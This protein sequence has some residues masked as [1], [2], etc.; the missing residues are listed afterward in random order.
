MEQWTVGPPGQFFFYQTRECHVPFRWSCADA[1]SWWPR[2][3]GLVQCGT[4][5]G[6]IQWVIFG[7]VILVWPLG[8]DVGLVPGIQ[9]RM[10]FDG[11]S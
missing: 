7:E 9:P 1:G 11:L 8:V 4:G 2:V 3:C 5:S 10:Q 6:E